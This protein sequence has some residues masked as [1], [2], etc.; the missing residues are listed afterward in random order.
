MM[1]FNGGVYVIFGYDASA[2]IQK[3][4]SISKWWQPLLGLIAIGVFV[5]IIQKIGLQ[6]I[7]KS[8]KMAAPYLPVAILLEAMRVYFDSR[9]THHLISKL[10]VSLDMSRKRFYL[11]HL[12]SHGVG[13][14][15]P[16]GRTAVEAIRAA[17]LSPIIGGAEATSVA[18][19]NQTNTLAMITLLSVPCAFSA[20]AV[21]AHTMAAA[22]W[23]NALIT[24]VFFVMVR[25]SLRNESLRDHLTR[26]FP[27]LKHHL[28]EFGET[29]ANEA[30]IE[31]PSVLYL[32]A[33]RL[34]Q[35]VLFAVFAFAV[36]I[37]FHM[38]LPWMLQGINILASLVGGPVPGQVGTSEAVFE[39]Y[40][41]ELQA[42]AAQA[43][44]IPIMIH[45]V[46]FVFAATGIV[47]LL[48]WRPSQRKTKGPPEANA[49]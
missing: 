1:H 30:F 7:V 14:I 21:G 36:N 47:L 18:A 31:L 25:I 45:A 37:P 32:L 16:G 5:W 28:N 23:S 6:E 26:G 24:G 17:L 43:V 34:S 22:L 10:D 42:T 40:H 38:L 39:S 49:G 19:S 15:A 4:K 2:L 41:T 3:K 13:L 27:M 35:T 20:H 11:I 12:A 8:M 9:S 44:S 48:L 33:A 46:Q 29:Q